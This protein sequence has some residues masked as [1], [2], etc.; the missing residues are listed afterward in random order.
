MNVSIIE[1][2]VNEIAIIFPCIIRAYAEYYVEHKCFPDI[3][4]MNTSAYVNFYVRGLIDSDHKIHN[5]RIVF[6]NDLEDSEVNIYNA[7]NCY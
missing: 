6:D 7:D 1:P 5:M 2:S 3:I 4:R